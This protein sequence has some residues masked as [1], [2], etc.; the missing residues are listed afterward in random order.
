[1]FE[2]EGVRLVAALGERFG[3]APDWTTRDNKTY[4]LVL[5][6]RRDRGVDPPL[7]EVREVIDAL[8]DHRIGVTI[9][10]MGPQSAEL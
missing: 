8:F 4:G 6:Y 2:A 1:M 10:V 9:A 7:G 5:L 3:P